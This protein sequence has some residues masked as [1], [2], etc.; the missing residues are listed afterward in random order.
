MSP[1]SIIS[2]FP[3]TLLCHAG[4]PH[5]SRAVCGRVGLTVNGQGRPAPRRLGYIIMLLG[6]LL[7][8][9]VPIIHIRGTKGML[10]GVATSGAAFSGRI[11]ALGVT[12]VY[13]V[14]FA[15]RGLWTPRAVNSR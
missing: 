15:A 3:R 5:P 7:G 1:S 2:C 11:L 8:A 14:I 9:L 6:S 10:G 12:A 4:L 13:S